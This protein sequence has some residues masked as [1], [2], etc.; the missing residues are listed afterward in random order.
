[1]TDTVFEK[2]QARKCLTCHAPEETRN[3]NSL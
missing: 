3:G 2:G 1:M